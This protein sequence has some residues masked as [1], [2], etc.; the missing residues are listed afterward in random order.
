MS[1]ALAEGG[2]GEGAR[3]GRKINKKNIWRAPRAPPTPGEPEP[4]EGEPNKICARLD[5]EVVAELPE[6]W[7]A[8]GKEM[9]R[10]VSQQMVSET[11]AVSQQSVSKC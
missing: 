8:T 3:A 6:S 4:G 5:L 11:S 7:R 9:L 1:P 10:A 2:L